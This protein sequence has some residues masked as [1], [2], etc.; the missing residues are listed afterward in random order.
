MIQRPITM[1]AAVLL[2][3]FV[4]G[5]VL[6]TTMWREAKATRIGSPL[7]VGVLKRGAGEANNHGIV[8][9][10]VLDSNCRMQL[11]PYVFLLVPTDGA[12]RPSWPFSYD[13]KSKTEEDILLDLGEHQRQNLRRAQLHHAVPHGKSPLNVKG[14]VPADPLHPEGPE[15]GSASEL[16]EFVAQNLRPRPDGTLAVLWTSPTDSLTEGSF[17]VVM[18]SE[19]DRPVA[20]IQSAKRRAAWLTPL[21]LLADVVVTPV[22]FGAYVLNGAG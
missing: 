2:M 20:D 15:G 7:V 22:I 6:T 1:A 4:T 18:R 3:P 10:Y 17:V 19:M 21:T 12:L 8:V 9:R 5:C 13:G 14:F 16:P 11:H